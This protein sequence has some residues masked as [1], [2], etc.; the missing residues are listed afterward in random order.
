M[1]KFRSAEVTIAFFRAAT[2]PQDRLD[3]L[4]AS[5][6]SR[7]RAW[8]GDVL[9]RA[10]NKYWRLCRF[11]EGRRCNPEIGRCPILGRRAKRK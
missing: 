7:K 9:W 5:R 8:D 3:E 2:T 10:Q 4:E 6:A 1:A 11:C